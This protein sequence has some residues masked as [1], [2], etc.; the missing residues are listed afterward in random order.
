[1]KRSMILAIAGAAMV[2]AG[3]VGTAQAQF[4]QGKRLNVLVNYGAGGSTDVLARLFSK[5]LEKH[6][7]GN[8]EVIVS[9]MP[10]A[11]GIVGTNHLGEVAKPDGMTL[12]FFA[13]SFMQ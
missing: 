1:M 9:N 13:T 4:Y 5:H 8:P 3:F 10:G 7:P 12:A 11:G 2:L 6:I